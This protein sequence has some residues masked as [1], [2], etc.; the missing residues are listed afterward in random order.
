MLRE[1]LKDNSIIKKDEKMLILG[2][3][4]AGVITADIV[5]KSYVFLTLILLSQGIKG[6]RQ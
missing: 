2:I 1:L 6:S 3:R 5:A 4:R